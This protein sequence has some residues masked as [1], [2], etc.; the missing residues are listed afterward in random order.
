MKRIL[1]SVSQNSNTDFTIRFGE[2]QKKKQKRMPC[3][4][5]GF[6]E[7]DFESRFGEKLRRYSFLIFMKQICNLLH[8]HS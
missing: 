7:T 5:S 4:V 8:N 2:K 6:C 1:N 3:S